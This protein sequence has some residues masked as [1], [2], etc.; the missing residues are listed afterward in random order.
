MNLE[1][2]S[3]SFIKWMEDNGYGTFGA[4]IF[5]N[6]IPNSAPDNAY[7]VVTAGGDVTRTLVTAQNVKQYSTQVFCRNT[8]GKAVEHKLFELETQVNTH[9][10]F[11]IDGFEIYSKQSTMPDDIDRDAE[12]RRQASLVVTMEIYK[13]YVS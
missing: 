2:V 3:E 11:N 4:D 7:W 10:S 12:N 6:F 1:T 13:S 9:G 5:L 8:S